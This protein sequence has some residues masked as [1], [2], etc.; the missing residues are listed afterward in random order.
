VTLGTTIVLT[1]GQPISRTQLDKR[2]GQRGQ[3]AILFIGKILAF[4]TPNAATYTLAQG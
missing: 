4:I 2:V 3:A 1:G